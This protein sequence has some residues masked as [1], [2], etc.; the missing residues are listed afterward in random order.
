MYILTLKT[1]IMIKPIFSR[2][3]SSDEFYT[4]VKNI[5]TSINASSIEQAFKEK[6]ISR[7]DTA[8]FNFE[9]ALNHLKK[10]PLTVVKEESDGT[11]DLR[12]LGFR[13][14]TEAL[15]YHWD[16]EKRKAATELAEI[17]RR[18]G[19]SL[20]NEGYTI[21]SAGINALTNELQKEP[22][23][24][25]IQKTETQEWLNQL[26]TA[27]TAFETTSNESDELDAKE[28]P[29][30]TSGRKALYKD[31]SATLSFIESQ[32]EFNPS[33]DLNRLIDNINQ[34]IT[35]I[36]AS[37]KARNTRKNSDEVVQE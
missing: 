20:H 35:G 17:I 29:L 26:I 3:L 5:K 19:W 27:Q 4:L 22:A 30:I 31:L 2:Y 12:F 9:S 7:L 10:N 34:I 18:H 13:T 21:Q 25:L 23:A 6:L 24:S 8:F 1:D 36:A 15:T 16:E 14:F 37:A 11:R 28:K 32:A 33:D